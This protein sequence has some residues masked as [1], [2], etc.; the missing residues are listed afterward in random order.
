MHAKTTQQSH[1]KNAIQKERGVI[2]T[3]NSSQEMQTYK[4]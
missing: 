1:N 2:H 4:K 3:Y